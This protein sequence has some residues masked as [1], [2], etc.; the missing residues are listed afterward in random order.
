MQSLCILE[1]LT[2]V[3]IFLLLK[4]TKYIYIYIYIFSFSHGFLETKWRSKL[5]GMELEFEVGG[6]VVTG[7]VW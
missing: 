4:F 5:Q 3:Y 6:G 1:M 2:K 7:C